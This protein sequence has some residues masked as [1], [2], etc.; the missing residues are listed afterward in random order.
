MKLFNFLNRDKKT[1]STA[2]DVHSFKQKSEFGNAIQ[3]E[4]LSNPLIK[5]MRDPW[6]RFGVDNQY[7]LV[8]I[9]LFNNSPIHSA[10]LNFKAKSLIGNGISIETSNSLEGEILNKKLTK[11]FNRSLIKAMCEDFVIHER[12]NLLLDNK[13]ANKL[14]IVR[15]D[16]VRYSESGD[17][18]YVSDFSK[19]DEV[20]QYKTNS[21]D[22]IYVYQEFRA[23]F[24]HYAVPSYIAAANWIWLD[25]EISLFQKSNI[26]NS[27]NPGM[28]I[29]F[30]KEINDKEKKKEFI[31][32][33]EAS[34]AGADK[35]GKRIITFSNGKDLAPD[36]RM[37]E[38]NT[39]DKAF[40]DTQENIIKNVCYSHNINPI[41]LGISTQG[42]LGATTEIED[43]YSIFNSVWLSDAQDALDFVFSEVCE[44]MG[45]DAKITIKRKERIFK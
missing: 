40:A 37:M 36:I 12:I 17:T 28:I 29:Q 9:D 10:I 15:A 13:A 19:R 39:L 26:Q 5:S 22:G 44:R 32:D 6:V 11:I 1:D 25:S 4:D 2:P 27:V 14:S 30:Y 8:L 33:F 16:S 43:A 23:G 34:F 18:A 24:E 3:G 20:K 45:W 21:K 41:I 7:P 42:K 38:A 35:A 31:R